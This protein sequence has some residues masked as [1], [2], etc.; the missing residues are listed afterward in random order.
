MEFFIPVWNCRNVDAVPATFAKVVADDLEP[1]ILVRFARLF[2][3][4]SRFVAK[5]SLNL[6][7]WEKSTSKERFLSALPE[8]RKNRERIL[9]FHLID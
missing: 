6:Q 3:N 1:E 2:E 4:L 5:K 7:N 8:K 9:T